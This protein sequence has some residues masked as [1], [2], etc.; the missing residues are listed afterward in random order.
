MSKLTI[1]DLFRKKLNSEIVTWLTCY[2]YSLASAINETSLDLILVGDSGGMVQL[3]YHDTNP[4]TMDEMILL[5]KSVRRGA[6][7]KFIVGDMPKGSYEISNE[8][9]VSNAMRFIKEA[10]CD[11]IKLEGGSIMADRVE[12][13]TRSGICVFGHVGLTPQSAHLFGGYRVVGKSEEE[14]H[15]LGLDILALQNSGAK[16]ILI[17]ATPNNIASEFA[18]TSQIPVY[19]IGA[20]TG[21]DGQLMILHDLLGLYPNFRPKFAT[22]LVPE[23]L[24]K[25]KQL[26]DSNPDLNAFG[27]LTRKDGFWEMA[28]LAVEEYC[29]IVRNK[30]FP[31]IQ[32]LY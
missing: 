16:A 13:I 15:T 9:A 17:E 10:H 29:S 20:G 7:D 4:V 8:D 2:D 27:K 3:G 19:G 32:H 21:L 26:L 5:A 18:S 1:Q 24:P 22:C 23:I 28:K 25:F 30:K 11:A 6:P 12:A 31:S 14:V